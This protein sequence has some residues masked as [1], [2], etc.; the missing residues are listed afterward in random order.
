MKY[1]TNAERTLYLL[2][3]V[4]APHAVDRSVHAAELRGRRCCSLLFKANLVH[5]IIMLPAC[6]TFYTLT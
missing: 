2:I 5:N 1:K 6:Y 4:Y 3:D